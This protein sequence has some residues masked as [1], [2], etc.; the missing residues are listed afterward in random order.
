MQA[1]AGKIHTLRAIGL[2]Q[3]AASPCE[4]MVRE[5]SVT[6]LRKMPQT[7]LTNHKKT[8]LVRSAVLGMARHRCR[9]L[10]I[11]PTGW[12]G[13]GLID[14]LK[15]TVVSVAQIVSARSMVPTRVAVTLPAPVPAASTT[16]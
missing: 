6:R 4:S 12:R 10:P 15:L 14:Q 3:S 11:R 1:P 7:H 5:S 2:V 9:H 13:E 16:E 8:A